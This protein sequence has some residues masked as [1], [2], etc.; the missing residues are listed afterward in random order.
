MARCIQIAKNAMGSAP[1]TPMV[2]A[3][4]VYDDRIIGEGYTSAFGGPHAEVNAIEAVNDKSLLSRATLYVTLE[5]CS[6]HGKTPPC[7]DLILKST[8][9]RVVIGLVDP[10]EKVAGNGIKK[11]TSGGCQVI[12]G[13]LEEECR[14]HHCRFLSFHENKRPY[15]ILKWAESADGYLAP[16]SKERTKDP[17]PHWI[18]S[19]PSRQMVHKW[20]SEEQAILVGPNTVLQDNPTLTTRNWKGKNPTRI[21]L[22]RSLRVP[23]S[24]NIMNGDAPT[25]VLTLKKNGQSSS[26]LVRYIRLAEEDFSAAGI[27]NVLWQQG[28]SSVIV[29]GGREILELFITAGLWDEARVFRGPDDLSDGLKAPEIKGAREETTPIGPD[30]LKIIRND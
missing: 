20:R 27:L 17:Q 3:V 1:P 15:V 14:D 16:E 19:E 21:L 28:L 12:T 29:E 9:P 6:H 22:D 4:L 8:I 5:P 25:L 7:S 24:S 26:D 2:G 30:L 10:H 18:S 23:S 11:L 13:I